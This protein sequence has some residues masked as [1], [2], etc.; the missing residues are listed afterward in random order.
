MST[1]TIVG[2]LVRD[3]ELRFTP[4]TGKA[5][6]N[7]TVAENH[8]RRSTDGTGWEDLPT[9]YWPVTV[10]GDQAEHLVESLTAGTRV[11]VVGRTGTMVWTPTEG[12]RAGTEQ[13]RLEVVAE[14][15]APSLRWATAQVT[16]LGRREGDAPAT[17]EPPF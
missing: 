11:V 13:R 3:P 17:E 10:W 8:R 16:K 12:E 14:E 15:V 2:N 9:S 7:L 6:A 4:T 1:I 5:V